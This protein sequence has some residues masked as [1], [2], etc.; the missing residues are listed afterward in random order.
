M[1]ETSLGMFKN[2]NGYNGAPKER[3]I[4]YFQLPWSNSEQA[5]TISFFKN[6]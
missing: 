4:I 2:N 3:T 1:I 5:A 6:Y